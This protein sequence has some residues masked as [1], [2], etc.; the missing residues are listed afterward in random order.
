MVKVCM[1]ILWTL[2]VISELNC[3]LRYSYLP[4]V[5]KIL[6]LNIQFVFLL[7]QTEMLSD[8]IYFVSQYS[9][10]SQYLVYYIY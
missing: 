6:Y 4:F 3:V 1:T 5:T 10:Y 7:H 2:D 9:V 8:K